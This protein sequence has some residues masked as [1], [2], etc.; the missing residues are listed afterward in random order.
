M[1]RRGI[2]DE[3]HM[4]TDSGKVQSMSAE[5]HVVGVLAVQ[6]KAIGLVKMQW[7]LN[8]CAP[9]HQTEDAQYCETL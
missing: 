6:K 3:G 8:V 7:E 5:Q 4:R 2:I 9:D 1:L